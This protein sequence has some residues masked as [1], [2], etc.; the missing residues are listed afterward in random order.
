MSSRSLQLQTK[1]LQEIEKIKPYQKQLADFRYAVLARV[2]SGGTDTELLCKLIDIRKGEDGWDIGTGTGLVA[3][4]MKRKGARYVL[5]TDKNPQAVRN[6]KINSRSLG[7]KIDV[8]KADV[9]GKINRRFHVITFN[10]PFTDH[11]SRKKYQIMFWDKG[12]KATKAFFS[13]L[14]HHL[15]RN[16]RAFICWSSFGSRT[17]LKRLAQRN[18]LAITH[19]GRRQGSDRLYY[20]VYKLILKPIR[21]SH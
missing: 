19:K 17:L 2:Y 18:K 11:A 4:A 1:K 8:K 20:D 9:F 6:A 16:G 7:I 15:T 10:P 21:V 5:A 14:R 12:N 3:L 13:G